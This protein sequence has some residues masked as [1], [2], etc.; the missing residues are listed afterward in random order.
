MACRCCGND[1]VVPV[2]DLG[3]QPWGNDFIMIEDGRASRRYPLVLEF[4]AACTMAQ[5]GHTVPKEVMFV[6]HNYISGTTRQL[7]SHFE[8]VARDILGRVRFGPHDYVLDIGGNDGT[9]LVPIKERGIRVVNV[10]SATLQSELSR[11]KGID[12][13][14]RFF[15]LEAAQALR[16]ERGPAKVIH[17]S[18]ILFHLEELHSAFDGIKALLAPDGFLVA[19]FIYLPTM[20]AQCAFDQVYHEHLVYYTVRSFNELLGRHG[21]RIADAAISPIHGG[22]CIA[23]IGHAGTAHETPAVADLRRREDAGGFGRIEVYRAFSGRVAALRTALVERVRALRAQGLRIQ[24][25]G[26][27]VKGSTIINYCGFTPDDI[28]CAVEVNE[29]KVGTYYPGTRSP[30]RHQ[31]AVAPP[32]VYL[33]LAWNFKDEILG[34]LDGFRAN[35]GRILVPIPEP[36]LI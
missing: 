26:A 7:R 14:N 22:S 27:P 30:V 3:S 6:N 13:V 2:L 19:E 34:K 15:N 18:G 29:F 35:G 4:C 25:L 24:A 9:F 8:G 11:R 1:A 5:I 33:L 36:A 32:D 17:G 23:W 28:E 10:E 31:H 12:T 21:L 16:Q 20:I